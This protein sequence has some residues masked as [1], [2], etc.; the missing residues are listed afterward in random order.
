MLCQLKTG[1]RNCISTLP[2]EEYAATVATEVLREP[3]YEFIKSGIIAWGFWNDEFEQ[4]E[5]H[6]K[7]IA[8]F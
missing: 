1:N 8:L 5:Q 7:S 2:H 4:I 3:S 6:L